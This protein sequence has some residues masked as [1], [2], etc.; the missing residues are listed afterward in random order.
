MLNWI[1]INTCK[2]WINFS[3]QS[4]LNSVVSFYKI[5]MYFLNGPLWYDRSVFCVDFPSCNDRRPCSEAS[6]SRNGVIARWQECEIV[7][8]A[9]LKQVRDRRACFAIGSLFKIK[10]KLFN[11]FELFDQFLLVD[12]FVMSIWIVFNNRA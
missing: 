11:L 12:R 7:T 3:I 5:N 8:N 4:N 10:V 1:D 2:W 9:I 6:V